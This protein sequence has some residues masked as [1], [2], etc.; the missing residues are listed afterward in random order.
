MTFLKNQAQK[1]VN[2]SLFKNRSQGE[3]TSLLKIELEN[4]TSIS[5]VKIEGLR[6]SKKTLKKPKVLMNLL[7][8]AVLLDELTTTSTTIDKKHEHTT[9]KVELE[10]CS[11]IKFWNKRK[12]KFENQNLDLN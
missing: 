1:K 5:K 3:I 4:E 2:K 9:H 8:L 11:R 12:Q 7:Q 10:A 6:S